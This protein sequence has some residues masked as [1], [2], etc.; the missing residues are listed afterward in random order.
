MADV[1]AAYP[2]IKLMGPMLNFALDD[3]DDNFGERRG[4]G[5]DRGRGRGKGRGKGKTGKGKMGKGEGRGGHSS[6]T[7]QSYVE[8]G[9][10]SED[11]NENGDGDG[12]DDDEEEWGEMTHGSKG[13][14]GAKRFTRKVQYLTETLMQTEN[15]GTE[16]TGPGPDLPPG[17]RSTPGVGPVSGMSGGPPTDGGNAGDGGSGGGEEEGRRQ[18][19]SFFYRHIAPTPGRLRR[20]RPLS[21]AGAG[22]YQYQSVRSSQGVRRPG[23]GIP[24][25]PLQRNRPVPGGI[26][27][28]VRGWRKGS[29]SRGGGGRG[30]KNARGAGAARP[31]SAPSRRRGQ[32]KGGAWKA[33]GDVGGKLKPVAAAKSSVSLQLQALDVAEGALAK[34]EAVQGSGSAG[35][36][37]GGSGGAGGKGEGEGEGK[38][39]AER[40]PSAAG[41]ARSL[42]L[43]AQDTAETALADAEVGVAV[44]GKGAEGKGEEG[45]GEE[46]KGEESEGG[47]GKQEGK[48]EGKEGASRSNTRKTT[49]HAIFQVMSQ[50]V[51]ISTSETMEERGGGEGDDGTFLAPP[52]EATLD[53]LVCPRCLSTVGPPLRPVMCSCG[54]AFTSG[55]TPQTYDLLQKKVHRRNREARQAAREAAVAGQDGAEPE[56]LRRGSFWGA[57]EY[58]EGRGAERKE[59]EDL[60][61]ARQPFM[62]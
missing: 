50:G 27:R 16:S 51:Q 53:L 15:W 19:R 9:G 22:A 49:Q 60:L 13:F 45:K 62:G 33:D 47:E 2:G 58:V 8:H 18:R 14:G 20:P 11:G 1:G 40:R 24:V 55:L 52:A 32:E 46:G 37:G 7:T 42:Q 26:P 31:S 59:R 28:P 17:W 54:E 10:G 21:A 38:G 5:R 6:Q 56:S 4:T 48:G 44:E 61:P 25:S 39:E 36:S 23:S 41:S 35:G 29:S 57:T 3:D 43:Q 34:A 12:D 30:K